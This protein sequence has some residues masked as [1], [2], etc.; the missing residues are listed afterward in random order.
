VRANP[1]P[2]PLGERER[3]VI[4]TVIDGLRL[5][6]ADGLRKQLETARVVGGLPTFLSLEVDRN[7]R[8]AAWTDGPQPGRAVVTKPGGEPVGEILVWTS[9][10]YLTALEYAWYSDDPPVEW[11]DPAWLTIEHE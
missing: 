4:S 10:G 7:A 3:H 2:G 8:R 6:D 11:P 5:A 1:T 9:D